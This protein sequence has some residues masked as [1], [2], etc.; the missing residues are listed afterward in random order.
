MLNSVARG[1]IRGPA[2]LPA[3]LLGV[4]DISLC[5]SDSH[6]WIRYENVQTGEVHTCGRYGRGFGGITDKISGKEVWPAA[7][8]GGVLWDQD[9][10]YEFGCRPDKRV[11]RVVR[12]EN[13]PIYRGAFHGRGHLGV[14]INCATYARDAWY[15]YSGEYYCLP[16]I[17]SPDAL[18]AHTR[19]RPLFGGR[20]TPL[21]VAHAARWKSKI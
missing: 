16:M 7:P 3:Q 14:R 10:L 9:L 12:M 13:P 8:T 1:E 19:K 4:W 20:L 2:E 5:V 18:E 15:F 11:L 17:A 21:G 6:A